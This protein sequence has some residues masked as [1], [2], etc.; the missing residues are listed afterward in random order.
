MWESGINKLKVASL[1]ERSKRDRDIRDAIPR[2]VVIIARHALSPST[3]SPQAQP[4]A[5]R[6]A[7]LRVDRSARPKQGGYHAVVRG[8]A[9]SR[10][11]KTLDSWRPHISSPPG[12]APTLGPFRTA[13]QQ[14]I[15]I[16]G[17]KNL[18]AQA[19]VSEIGIDMTRFPSDAHLISWA[20]LCPRNDESAGK[21]RSSRLDKR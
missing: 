14:V 2:H 7:A 21:R 10:H 6:Y 11:Q 20:G 16:P 12:L 18:G 3:P 17:I 13:I 9:T 1:V 8:S 19:I 4:S 5:L 15:S